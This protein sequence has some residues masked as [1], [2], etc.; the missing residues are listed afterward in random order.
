M[1]MIRGTFRETQPSEHNSDIWPSETESKLGSPD[2]WSSD[3]EESEG[4][5]HDG[6]ESEGDNEIS[7]EALEIPGSRP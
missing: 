4:E 2:A 3:D 5:E 7:A 6:D 1:E